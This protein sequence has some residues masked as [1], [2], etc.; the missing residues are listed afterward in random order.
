MMWKPSSWQCGEFRGTPSVYSQPC[1]C[2][3]SIS[4]CAIHKKG[5][6]SGLVGNYSCFYRWTQDSVTRFRSESCPS[7]CLSNFRPNY[8]PKNT[9]SGWSIQDTCLSLAWLELSGQLP[10]LMSRVDITWTFSWEAGNLMTFRCP[11][12]FFPPLFTS[13]RWHLK[14]VESRSARVKAKLL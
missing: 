11:L 7:S 4:F 10:P 3:S 13:V 14:N 6:H 5:Q 1:G 2:S 9:P 12:D 8:S